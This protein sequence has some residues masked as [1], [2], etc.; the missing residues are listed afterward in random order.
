MLDLKFIRENSEKVAT[1]IKLKNVDI[2]VQ[3]VINLDKSRREVIQQLESLRKQRNDVTAEI[4]KL[5]KNKEDASEKIASMKSVNTEISTFEAELR[6]TEAQLNEVLYAI[7][8]LPHDSVPVGGEEDAVEVRSWGEQ[9]QFDFEARPH[10][11]LGEALGLIDLERG[12]KLS[13]SGF[14]LFTGAGAR[15]ERAL[16]NLM[17]DIHTNEHGYTE[18]SPPFMVNTTTM[19]GTGQLPKMEEDMYQLADQTLWLVPT[20]EVP[21]T[22]IHANE[23]LPPDALPKLFVA[24]T[25]CFRREAGAAGKDTRG[26]IRVHQFDKVEM[27]RIVKPETSYDELE[28]ITKHAERILQLLDLHYRVRE[29]ATGDLSFA[30]AKC[31]DLEVWAPGVGK[32]LEVSSCSNFEDFQAR[33]MNMRYRP[34]EGEKPEFPHTLNGSGLALPRTVIAILESY[35][36][37]DGKIRV[38]EALQPYLG[39]RKLIA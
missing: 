27:V 20:A 24:Y 31:Y 35:Q 10:W 12:A 34:A 29:L 30:A 3:G 6:D 2:D 22:N 18:V 15:L 8:N 32:Y 36:T 16:I 7:P 11:E 4:A 39:G 25:P 26:L 21:V 14:I 33:R 5:K 38:P 17:I 37:E 13:G 19:T 23:I 1:G 28:I 9:P